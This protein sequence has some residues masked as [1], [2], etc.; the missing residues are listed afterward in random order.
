MRKLPPTLIRQC[1]QNMYLE[2][3]G[4]SWRNRARIEGMDIGIGA[5][6]PLH[7]ATTFER[8]TKL[9]NVQSVDDGKRA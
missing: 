4:L 9:F 7:H 8:E 5:M 2:Y 3:F 1:S 6:E